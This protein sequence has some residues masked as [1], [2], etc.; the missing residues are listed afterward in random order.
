[1]GLARPSENSRPLANRPPR[2]Y[3]LIVSEEALR[4]WLASMETAELVA[5]DTETTSLDPMQALLVGLSFSTESGRAAYVRALA[6]APR[7][8]L[9]RRVGKSFLPRLGPSHGCA[10]L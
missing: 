6:L 7:R 5:F 1:M 2:S 4:S 10:P 9:L 8:V 3:E